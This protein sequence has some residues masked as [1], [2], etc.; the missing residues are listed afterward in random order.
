MTTQ[1]SVRRGRNC[2]ANIVST[3]ALVLASATGGA[4]GA[5]FI[6]GK[7]IKDGSVTGNDIRNGSLHKSDLAAA[8]GPDVV[9]RPGPEGFVDCTTPPGCSGR[10][11]LTSMAATC[12]GHE[13]AVGGGLTMPGSQSALT[14]SRPAFD[15]A[16][17]SKRPT[18]WTGSGVID[19]GIEP[20]G[21]IALP[22]AWVLCAAR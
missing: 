3:M 22:R 9:V 20:Q 16:S 15:E 11:E 2:Y 17:E 19:L 6:N 12:R 8:P 14:S 13:V 7:D 1:P 5:S 18:G 4:M 10:H 21:S